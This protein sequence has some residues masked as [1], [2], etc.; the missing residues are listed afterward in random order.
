[1]LFLT[2]VCRKYYERP[3]QKNKGPI[4]LKLIILYTLS[5]LDLNFPT[6][7]TSLRV[8]HS[9]KQG[10]RKIAPPVRFLPEVVTILKNLDKGWYFAIKLKKR[11]E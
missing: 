8:V 9:C 5:Q 10:K 1:M 3:E 2:L 11:G 7:S 4:R 6:I